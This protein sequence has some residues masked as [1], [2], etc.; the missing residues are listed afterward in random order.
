MEV[1]VFPGGACGVGRFSRCRR[2]RRRRGVKVLL[3]DMVELVW[4]GLGVGVWLEVWMGGVRVVEGGR[5]HRAGE[6]LVARVDL[7]VGVLVLLCLAR[8]LLVVLRVSV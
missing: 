6:A 5:G 8:L 7:V 3:L 2:C 4:V 1:L